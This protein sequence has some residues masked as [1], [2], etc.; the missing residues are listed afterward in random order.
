[1]N[2]DI[3]SIVAVGSLVLSFFALLYSV[4]ATRAAEQQAK[5]ADEQARAIP[6]Q[7]EAAQISAN[8]A[9]QQAEIAV[10]AAEETKRIA[11]LSETQLKAALRPILELERRPPTLYDPIDYLVNKGD[12]IAL[13][14]RASYGTNAPPAIQ[15]PLTVASG[16]ETVTKVDWAR[17]KD[18]ALFLFYESEDG[19]RFRT[20][21]AVGS[22]GHPLHHHELIP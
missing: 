22:N 21:T 11:K 6:A 1:M 5:S 4:R 7:L 20:K 12:G 15:V 19:R 14:V 10:A 8:A 16:G 3:S 9:K 17:V 2:Q 13:N 18:E